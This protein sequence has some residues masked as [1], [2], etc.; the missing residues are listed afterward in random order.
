MASSRHDAFQIGA[1][2]RLVKYN[3]GKI[4]PNDLFAFRLICLDLSWATIHAALEIINMEN[5]GKYA[6]RV[7]SVA[8]NER[9]I[10]SFD[11]LSWLASCASHTMHRYVRHVKKSNIFKHK[12]AFS[13]STFCFSLL[14]NSTTLNETT[15]VFRLM[16]IVFNSKFETSESKL[17]FSTLSEL[18]KV[19]PTDPTEIDKIVNR[20]FPSFPV[21]FNFEFIS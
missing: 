18:L 19:R 17:A 3:Y 12:H 20:N 10:D 21:I 9:S 13:F 15:I 11:R 5:I 8:K 4:F 6:Q 1:M 7:Y 14:L 16:C 2:F